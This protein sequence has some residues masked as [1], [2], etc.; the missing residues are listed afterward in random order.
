LRKISE[1]GMGV[2]WE[3]NSIKNN[4]RLVVKEPLSNNDHDRMKVERLLI[5]ALVLRTINDE[6]VEAASEEDRLIHLHVVR[7]LD[8]LSD[9][10]HPILVL[11]FID[12]K[13]MTAGFKGKA[14]AEREAVQETVNLLTVVSAIHSRGVIHRDISPSNI[15][16]S[17]SR[18]QVLIDFGASRVLNRTARSHGLQSGR[19]V[20][21]KGFSAP[22]L[23]DGRS[24]VRSDVF[25]VGATLLYLLTA[26]NPGD[27]FSNSDKIWDR[28][29]ST[30]KLRISS[31]VSDVIQQAMAPDPQERFESAKEMLHPL[32]EWLQS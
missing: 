19:V 27:F 21:K 17:P 13:S 16:L 18:G 11:E 6:L 3:A 25:S 31:I 23:L 30:L 5:E 29:L 9:P 12:G 32:T 14:L 7:Y 20:F 8:Q 24:D 15:I 22:E 1:G 28:P 2:V 10:S 26:R 4:R